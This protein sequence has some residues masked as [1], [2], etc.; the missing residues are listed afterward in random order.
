MQATGSHLSIPGTLILLQI[1]NSILKFK[2]K[3]ERKIERETI[4]IRRVIK[5][6]L[7]FLEDGKFQKLK[8]V[9]KTTDRTLRF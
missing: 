8:I 4:N 3:K 5:K 7:K 1:V 6:K 2:K 9:F